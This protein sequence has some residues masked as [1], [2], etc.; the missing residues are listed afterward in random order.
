M[1]HGF[2]GLDKDAHFITLLIRHV[3]DHLQTVP[4]PLRPWTPH[5][6]VLSLRT[7]NIN[8]GRGSGIAWSTQAVNI[9]GFNI[10]I[11]TDTRITD[12]DYFRNRL[13]YDVV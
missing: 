11:L 2:E 12:E 5:P 3:R 8:N 4:P 13:G 6:W 7:L 10:M 1:G 9:G